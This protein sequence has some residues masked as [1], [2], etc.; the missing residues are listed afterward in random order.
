MKH[1]LQ[2]FLDRVGKTVIETYRKH[3]MHLFISDEHEAN[4]CHEGQSDG[5]TFRDP[6]PLSS[7][8]L[9]CWTLECS[10]CGKIVAEE[11]QNDHDREMAAN[12]F[13]GDGWKRLED[14]TV[15]CGCKK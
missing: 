8:M 6:H 3:D 7:A 13:E 2:W 14:G 4:D 12:V 1:P 9:L 15:N 11:G 5:W 10:Y